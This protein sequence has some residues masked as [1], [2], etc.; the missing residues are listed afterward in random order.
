MYDPTARISPKVSTMM[1]RLRAVI[2]LAASYPRAA[3]FFFG[4]LHALWESIMAALAV[5]TSP[6]LPLSLTARAAR[7]GPFAS[8]HPGANADGNSGACPMGRKLVR[9]KLRH[10][11]PVRV[12]YIMAFRTSRTSSTLRRRAPGMAGGIKGAMRS[13]WA[14]V[15]SVG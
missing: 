10:W 2:C 12:K 7:R 8:S 9:G 5:V 4:A 13:H 3:P 11:Q 14:S 1:W 6:V 15:R